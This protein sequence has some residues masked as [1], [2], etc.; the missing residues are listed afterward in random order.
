MKRCNRTMM[1]KKEQREKIVTETI[2]DLFSKCFPSSVQISCAVPLARTFIKSESGMELAICCFATASPCF[3]SLVSFLQSVSN[4]VCSAVNAPLV[5][6]STEI[7]LA[8]SLLVPSTWSKIPRASSA[9]MKRS[10]KMTQLL[11]DTSSLGM[12]QNSSPSFVEADIYV[13]ESL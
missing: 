3:H 13:D 2:R 5:R 7:G 11:P 6:S 10:L 8:G 1:T 4:F 9:Q 12:R